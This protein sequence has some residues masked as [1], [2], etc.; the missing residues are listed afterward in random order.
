M[1]PRWDI[2][3][4]EK[5]T[6]SQGPFSLEIEKIRVSQVLYVVLHQNLF[7]KHPVDLIICFFICCCNCFL[8]Q[9]VPSVYYVLAMLRTKFFIDA[10]HNFFK[11]LYFAPW[12]VRTCKHIHKLLEWVFYRPS[13]REITYVLWDNL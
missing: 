11:C 8:Y 2:A 7:S 9:K 6:R 10:A 5:I 4:R 1:R 12:K 13:W 3:H